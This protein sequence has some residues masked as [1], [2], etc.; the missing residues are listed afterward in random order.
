MSVLAVVV[1][2]GG[3][4]NIQTLG[5]KSDGILT[6]CIFLIC[7]EHL[8]KMLCVFFVYKAVMQEGG[9]ASDC[10][11]EMALQNCPLVS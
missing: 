4:V 11:G 9:I 7:S 10:K 3:V 2:E 1:A 8:V 6:Y 5:V